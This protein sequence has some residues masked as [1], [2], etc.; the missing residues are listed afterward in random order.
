MVN[1]RQNPATT[2]G[3]FHVLFLLGITLYLFE[4]ASPMFRAWEESGFPRLSQQQRQ[5]KMSTASDQ[6]SSALIALNLLQ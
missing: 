1:R 4:C 3:H 2:S 5:G 6:W